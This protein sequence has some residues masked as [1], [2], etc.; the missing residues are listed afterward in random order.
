MKSLIT[1]AG[2]A[3][4]GMVNLD[5][6]PIGEPSLSK[7]WSVSAKL[8]GFYD[9]NYNTV[10]DSGTIYTKEDSFGFSV[11][12][13]LGVNF[14]RDQTTLSLRYDFDL[15]WYESRE[16]DE[17]DMYH[18]GTLDLAHS[19]NERY[20]LELHDTF[21]YTDEP[22]VGEGQAATFVRTKGNNLRNYA[23]IGLVGSFT[24]YW[25]FRVGYENTLYDYEE[26]GPGSRSA[27][28]DRLEHKAT[29]DLRRVL[30]PTT[31]ALL[32]YS[33]GY[34][35]YTAD[36]R[37]ASGSTLMSD[38]RDYLSHFAFA[39]LNHEFNP[40]FDTQ[41]RVGAQIA[42]FKNAHD[43]HVRPYADAALGYR[44]AEGS[45]IQVG[46]KSG[47]VSTDIALDQ[48]YSGVTLATDSTTLYVGLSHRLTERLTAQARGQWQMLQY[49]GQGIGYN[50][51]WDNYY[52][53]DASLIY[54]INPNLAV[55]V[56]YLYDKLDSDIAI[57]GYT[58]HRAY[59][60]LRATY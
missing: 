37:L 54:Q 17:L 16:D 32:G 13:S 18:A 3:A 38:Y 24:E 25:G 8:R 46:V 2:L 28:L 30:Q 4:V 36:E 58:R 49:I 40:Q 7:P 26:R 55:D 6:Q 12:P 22:M 35:T 56:G 19:F 29:V 44:Y 9:S 51:E 60:G 34:T 10:P 23:G 39:G 52:A 27:L 47:F 45:R 20:R 53:A 57:R 5:A 33:F 42:D 11:A 14:F 21:A 43:D 48:S 50:D 41:I 15:R 59:L 1:C 31:T